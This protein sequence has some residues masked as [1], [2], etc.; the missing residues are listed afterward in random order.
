MQTVVPTA[1]TSGVLHLPRGAPALR[2]SQGWAELERFEPQ[3]DQYPCGVDTFN[4]AVHDV[5][6]Y[7]AVLRNDENFCQETS[8]VEIFRARRSENTG[9]LGEYKFQYCCYRGYGYPCLDLC[10]DEIRVVI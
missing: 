2:T 9:G 10:I 6:Y 3:V 8:D 7:Q 1:T 5:R 4:P